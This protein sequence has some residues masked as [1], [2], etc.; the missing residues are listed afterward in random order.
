MG[1]AEQGLIG[2]TQGASPLITGHIAEGQVGRRDPLG[3][4]LVRE[5]GHFG[6][7]GVFV[8]LADRGP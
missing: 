3:A 2:P 4:S 1:F 7:N 6:L 5:P 8:A